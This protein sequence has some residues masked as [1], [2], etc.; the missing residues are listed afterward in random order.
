MPR[1]LCQCGAKGRWCARGGALGVDESHRG[2][3]GAE[4]WV[5][6]SSSVAPSDALG[7]STDRRLRRLAVV[8][9]RAPGAGRKGRC[10]RSPNNPHLWRGSD[11]AALRDPRGDLRVDRSRRCGEGAHVVLGASP[12]MRSSVACGRAGGGERTSRGGHRS[13]GQPV[14]HHHPSRRVRSTTRVRSR[15][16]LVTPPRRG[17]RVCHGAPAPAAQPPRRFRR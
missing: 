13:R 6:A 9:R 12:A 11:A 8:P 14:I 15:A 17:R 3:C 5:S 10:H 1:G 16:A 7:V 2:G 4:K